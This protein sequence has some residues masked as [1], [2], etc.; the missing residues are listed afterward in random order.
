MDSILTPSN[1]MFVIGIV[2]VLFSVY[3]YFRNPQDILEKT[4]AVD[5][6]KD[7]GTIAK[8]EQRAQWEKEANEKKFTE[9]GTRIN[10]SMTLAQN[11]IHTIDTKVDGLVEQMGVMSNKVTELTTIINERIPKK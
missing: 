1:I 7:D 11:H 10:D 3:T 2:G 8:L 9:L 6:A 4:L 5:R